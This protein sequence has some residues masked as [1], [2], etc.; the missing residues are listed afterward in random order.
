MELYQIKN[1]LEKDFSQKVDSLK[2]TYKDNAKA[3]IF[4]TKG[5]DDRKGRCL[6]VNLVSGAD[7]WFSKK[8]VSTTLWETEDSCMFKS[9]VVDFL[10]E[11]AKA[12]GIGNIEVVDES[13]GSSSLS[14]SIRSLEENASDTYNES[15]EAKGHKKNKV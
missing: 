13:F 14:S 15:V 2:E 9:D 12:H 10:Y 3:I 11:L 5:K 7:V 4:V 6:I 1:K 8:G